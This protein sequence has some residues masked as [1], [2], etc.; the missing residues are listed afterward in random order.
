MKRNL[1]FLLSLMM[2][3]GLVIG[4]GTNSLA[5]SVV[6]GSYVK[7]DNENNPVVTQ[8]YGAD[9]GVMVYNDEVF[10]YA[11]NDSQ[12]LAGNNENTYEKIDTL[13]CYSS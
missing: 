7:G 5:A 3:G 2:V 9:P 4:N 8:N 1:T 12:E 11:T 6:N 13:N 10:I